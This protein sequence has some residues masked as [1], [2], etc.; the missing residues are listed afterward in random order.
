MAT[1]KNKYGREYH[2]GTGI[3]QDLRSLIIQEIIELGGNSQ[4]GNVPR[5]IYVK[6]ANTFRVD[7][8]SV[9]TF[10]KKYISEGSMSETARHKAGNPKLNG[11]DVQLVS[12]LKRNTPSVTGNKIKRNLCKYSPVS[13]NVHNSTIYR[14]M[15][16]ELDLTYKRI[17]R[18]SCDRF[19]QYNMQYTQAFIDFCQTKRADQIKFMDESGFKL[20][21]TNPAYGHS[22]KGQACV[23]IGKYRPGTNLT[24]NLLVGLN[25]VLYFNFVNGASNMNT[26]LNFW[27]EASACQDNMG[28]PLFKPGDVVIV[29]NC[30]IHH[31]HAERVLRQ[32]F[33]MQGVQYTFLPV[34]SPNFNPVE[35]CFAKIKN[36]FTQERFQ[37]LAGINLKLAIVKAI[38]EVSETDIR[39]F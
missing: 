27:G 13:G 4:S 11:A 2:N 14:A 15:S 39:G 30:S 19:T 31:N 34:Y 22:K 35:N 1:R 32:Y 6:V 7:E 36:I 16:R 26:Y 20:T 25:G 3:S 18:P 12:F 28:C 10:W 8:K 5:G 38:E 23:E 9:R 37:D 21:T 17:N 33:S 29:D 24:L